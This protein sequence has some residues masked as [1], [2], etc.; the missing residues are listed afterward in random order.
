MTK[1]E[2]LRDPFETPEV[3]EL[4][5]LITKNSNYRLSTKEI[6]VNEKYEENETRREDKDSESSSV[7]S[8]PP[9]SAP[10]TLMNTSSP[11][12]ESLESGGNA[13]KQGA[14]KRP[15]TTEDED[16]VRNKKKRAKV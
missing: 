1:I 11:N 16:G 9:P 5:R 14:G 13:H 10:E 6:G 12:Q 7:G 4:Y 15:A 8:T 3:Q 2:T